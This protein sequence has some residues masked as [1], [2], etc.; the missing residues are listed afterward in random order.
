MT[1]AFGGRHSIQLSYGCPG[2]WI[3]HLTRGG[4]RRKSYRHAP[5]RA[6]GWRHENGSTFMAEQGDVRPGEVGIDLPDA[7]DAGVYFIGRI[8]TPFKSRSHCPKNTAESDAIGRIELD[9]RFAAGLADLQLFSH[10]WLL[11]WM[12]Q[13]RRDLIQQVPAHLGRPRG[14]FALRSPV[15][16]NPIAIAAVELIGVAGTTLTVRKV[17]CIDGTPLIDIKPYFASI[18][19]FPDARRPR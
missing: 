18:D 19:S 14:T 2:L 11:Y 4:K 5:K 15:R 8:R 3:L 16:P 10:L 9:Q 1:F 17:D 13:A 12:H 6:S 7:F